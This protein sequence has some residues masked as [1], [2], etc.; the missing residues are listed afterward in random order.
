MSSSLNAKIKNN[1]HL[2]KLFDPGQDRA[3]IASQIFI[4]I[5]PGVSCEWKTLCWQHFWKLTFFMFSGIVTQLFLWKKEYTCYE[6]EC[7]V[8][9]LI[10]SEQER[11][12]SVP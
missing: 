2:Q 1:L 10:V 9:P 8:S 12:K 6:Q 4:C 7:K 5:A 3:F 11:V